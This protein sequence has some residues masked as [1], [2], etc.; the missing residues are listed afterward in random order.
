M[1]IVLVVAALITFMYNSGVINE[2]LSDAGFLNTVYL[3]GDKVMS[4]VKDAGDKAVIQAY[5]QM[6]DE[7]SFT[8][9]MN[10][11]EMSDFIESDVNDNFRG[12]ILSNFRLEFAKYKFKESYLSMTQS[13]ILTED[14]LK[15]ELS[16]DIV[17]LSLVDIGYS[18]RKEVSGKTMASVDY[19]P[20]NAEKINL[21]RMGITDF[22]QIYLVSQKCKA[23]KDIKKCFEDSLLN[24]NVE[25]AQA[26]EKT[27]VTLTSK[28]KF[29]I[30]DSLRD[31]KMEFLI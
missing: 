13:T 28:K 1:V 2:K 10:N 4:Y 24:F 20:A 23:E 9:V 29:L 22:K 5:N 16:N 27:K 14:R 7:K 31:I 11:N 17:Q 8:G 15:V 19:W 3:K 25:T 12:K 21:T 18:D 26:G 6:I 30:S